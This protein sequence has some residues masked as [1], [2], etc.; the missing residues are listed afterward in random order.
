MF[1]GGA[2]VDSDLAWRDRPGSVLKN[3]RIEPLERLV[4]SIQ[5]EAERRSATCGDGLVIL[6]GELRK[7]ANS[8]S[9]SINTIDA[10][11]VVVQRLVKGWWLAE[12]DFKDLGSRDHDIGA[13]VGVG[14]K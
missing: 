3:K 9:R 6:I 14:E 13:R 11:H 5:T 1:R 4:L 2:R 10:N 12:V 8:T 7:V